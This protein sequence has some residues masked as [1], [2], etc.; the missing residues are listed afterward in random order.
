MATYTAITGGSITNEYSAA[1]NYIP[2]LVQYA[3]ANGPHNALTIAPTGFAG[4]MHTYIDKQGEEQ[5]HEIEFKAGFQMIA[6]NSGDGKWE[7][8]YPKG[9][10]YRLDLQGWA[11]HDGVKYA[12]WQLQSNGKNSRTVA[13]IHLASG[14]AFS[15]GQLIHGLKLSAKNLSIYRM[16]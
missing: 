4:H 2:L 1:V 6:P 16:D 14:H 7:G 9:C 10:P 13:A 12:N 3:A 15:Q 5:T 11:D 8:H